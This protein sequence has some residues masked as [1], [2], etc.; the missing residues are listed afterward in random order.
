VARQ[1]V[2]FVPLTVAILCWGCCPSQVSSQSVNTA[3]LA[4]ARVPADPEGVLSE[5]PPP[6]KHYAWQCPGD[7][8]ERDVTYAYDGSGLSML[9]VVDRYGGEADAATAFERALR[10]T[11]Y[12]RHKWSVRGSG[13]DRCAVSDWVRVRE[14]PDV[15][16]GLLMCYHAA[17]S[18]E[19]LF[20]GKLLVH[21]D[22]T[23]NDPAESGKD[24]FIAWLAG[25][26]ETGRPPET[27]VPLNP[28]AP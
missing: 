11:E 2:G 4:R 20:Q 16:Q 18:S 15:A 3:P 27:P 19:V 22:E 24:A 25:V 7:P 13:D 28:P 17:P 6:F 1:R 26:L 5:F 12:R 21:L 23:V 10:P 14:K 8:L 9:V